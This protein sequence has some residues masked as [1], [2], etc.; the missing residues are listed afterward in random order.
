MNISLTRY[1]F[2]SFSVRR[3]NACW[4][5]HQTQISSG[6]ATTIVSHSAPQSTRPGM[7]NRRDQ[8]TTTTIITTGTMSTILRDQSVVV[9]STIS[10]II[11]RTSLRTRT[12]ALCLDWQ[13]GRIAKI[14]ENCIVAY[15]LFLLIFLLPVRSLFSSSLSLYASSRSPFSFSRSF[16]PF[17]FVA[18]GIIRARRE[19]IDL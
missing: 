16:L 13:V 10:I 4:H 5:S 6:R 14:R 1:F 9:N 2:L 15:V 18:S 8:A 11:R 19:T 7:R 12:G 17:F 3:S